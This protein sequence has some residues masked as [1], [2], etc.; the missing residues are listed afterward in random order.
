MSRERKEEGKETACT[1]S[2]PFKNLRWYSRQKHHQSLNRII[3]R[4]ALKIGKAQTKHPASM[5][6]PKPVTVTPSYPQLY[7]R[8]QPPLPKAKNYPR[9]V[10]RDTNRGQNC[11]KERLRHNG[12]KMIGRLAASILSGSDALELKTVISSLKPQLK[13]SG[14]WSLPMY[15][16]SR[17][18]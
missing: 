4:P 17:S 10:A 9:R 15:H 12:K 11:R 5:P 18:W 1:S 6:A 8:S 2:R 13:R 14:E 16:S 3:D 7:P